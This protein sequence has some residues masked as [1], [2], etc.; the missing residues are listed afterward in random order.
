MTPL[1][2]IVKGPAGP[3]V[4]MGRQSRHRLILILQT[5]TKNHT[6]F[7]LV[8]VRQHKA[9][10]PAGKYFRECRAEIFCSRGSSFGPTPGTFLYTQKIGHIAFRFCTFLDY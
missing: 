1:H 2:E 8:I 4:G 3:P 9:T 5:K 7:S 10:L 6:T